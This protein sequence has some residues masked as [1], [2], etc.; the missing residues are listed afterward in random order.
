MKHQEQ[1]EEFVD[2]LIVVVHAAHESNPKCSKKDRKLLST[3]LQI[4]YLLRIF[5]I[6]QGKFCKIPRKSL[7]TSSPPLPPP[8]PATTSSKN[9]YNIH[10]SIQIW[11][12]WCEL[13]L[14]NAWACILQLITSIFCRIAANRKINCGFACSPAVDYCRFSWFNDQQADLRNEITRWGQLTSG[15]RLRSHSRTFALDFF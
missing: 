4:A 2:E 15:R 8:P 6:L 10:F 14:S 5:K 13:W 1:L 3:N 12:Y 11:Q 7:S 9:G